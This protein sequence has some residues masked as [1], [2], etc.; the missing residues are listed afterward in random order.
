MMYGELVERTGLL[1]GDEFLAG[2]G[3]VQGLPGPM[4]SFA[5]FAGGLAARSPG[6]W[7]ASAAAYQALGAAIGALG[8]FLPG[9][10][11]IFFVYPLWNSIRSVPAIKIAITGVN[12]VAGGDAG[13]GCDHPLPGRWDQ[14]GNRACGCSNRSYPGIHENTGPLHGP[15]SAGCRPAASIM[16]TVLAE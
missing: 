6:D 10:L 13:L 8:I 7:T 4:F 2:Y 16:T 11:L 12:A 15:G 9:L 1:T 3:L 14:L 5:S